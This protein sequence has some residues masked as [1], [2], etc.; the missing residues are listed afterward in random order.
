MN[1]RPDLNGMLLQL[2]DGI[3]IYQVANGKRQR[4]P[5]TSSVTMLFIPGA[6]IISQAGPDEP[7]TAIRWALSTD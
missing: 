5:K 6:R 7:T 4:V 1:L 2:P 3:E